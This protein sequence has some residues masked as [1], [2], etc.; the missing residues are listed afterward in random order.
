MAKILKSR[1]AITSLE[2]KLYDMEFN[3][4]N[5]KEKQNITKSH[6]KLERFMKE[7]FYKLDD[8]WKCTVKRNNHSK[9][10]VKHFD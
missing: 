3:Q 5:V 4:K 10:Q 1:K 8:E 2:S 6:R 7:L 9:Q